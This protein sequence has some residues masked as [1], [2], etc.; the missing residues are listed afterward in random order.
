MSTISTAAAVALPGAGRTVPTLSAYLAN[1]AVLNLKD[2]GGVVDGATDDTAALLA[3]VAAAPA[4][5]STILIPGFAKISGTITINTPDVTVI[6]PGTSGG[7][8]PANATFNPFTLGP[9]AHRCK[10]LNMWIKGAAVDATTIQFGIYTNA[11]AAPDD[12][13]IAGCFFGNPLI[14]GVNSLNSAIKIDGGNGWN[15]HHCKAKYLWGTISN[16]GYGILAGTTN[17]LHAHDN[18][19]LGTTGRGRH[20]V[21]LSGGCTYC[22]VHDNH[23]ENLAEDGFP[24]FSTSIQAAG[25]GNHVHNNVAI[26]CGQLTAG[27]AAFSVS[28][29][30]SRNII[31]NNLAVNFQGNGYIVAA[32]GVAAITDGNIFRNNWSYFSQWYGILNEGAQNTDI[33]GNTFAESSRSGSNNYAAIA[34]RPSGAVPSSGVTVRDNK[35]TGVLLRAGMDLT[36]AV[37]ATG[38]RVDNNYFPDGVTSKIDNPNNVLFSGQNNDFGLPSYSGNQ[39]DVSVTLRVGRDAEVDLFASSLTANRTVT[40]DTVSAYSGAKFRI[41]R[42]GL[43]A[44]TLDVGGLKTIPISTVAFVDVQYESGAWK[45]SGYGTL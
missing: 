1:N 30:S 23:A 44:F 36:G 10:F 6:G 35:G 25:I 43:G 34:V 2:F 39:G 42:T 7:I 8:I 20:A 29:N 12:V 18:E 37:L 17:K 26:N 22:D 13:E 15:V 4:G 14:G 31:E 45:L 16:T 32:L 3:T 19:F 24:I 41:V 21:Y 28:G 11:L 9:L 27:S 40:L 33:F 38:L 5:G